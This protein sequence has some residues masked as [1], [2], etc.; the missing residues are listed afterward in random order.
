MLTSSKMC[1]IVLGDNIDTIEKN[2]ET[3]IDATKEVGLEIN[4][5]KTKYMLLSRNQNAGQN[6]DIKIA[7][8]SF[9]NVSQFKYL[10]ITVTNQNLIQEEIRRRLSSG[11]AC[12]HSVH[13]LL[14]SRLLSKNLKMRIYKTVILYGCETRS[15]T[16]REEHGLRVFENKVL[17]RIFGPKRDEVTRGWRK[18]PSIIRII[19]SRRMR[20]A[21]HVRMGGKRNVYRLL[22]GKPEGKR[23]LG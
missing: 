9:E 22:V 8:R 14:S 21:G 23:P 16:L 19:K 13:S 12:Y 20:W 17:R 5:G 3:L 7:N 10:G 2:T 18:L 4:V 15:L 6:R 11:N 1:S